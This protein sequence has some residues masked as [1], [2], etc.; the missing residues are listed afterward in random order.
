MSEKDIVPRPP[1][2]S[3]PDTSARLTYYCQKILP[4][5]YDD[6]LSYYEI[7]CKV[8]KELNSSMEALD[9]LNVNVKEVYDYVEKLYESFDSFATSGFEDYYKTMMGEWLCK[10]MPDILACAARMFW[11]SLDDCGRIVISIPDNWSFITFGF[12][13][14]CQ[15]NPEY[16]RMVLTWNEIRE[17]GEKCPFECKRGE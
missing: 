5:V 11:V 13:T 17:Y 12:T 10:N 3:F 15:N 1:S 9:A 2:L 8:A 14:M 16:G 7:V 6:S 4:A